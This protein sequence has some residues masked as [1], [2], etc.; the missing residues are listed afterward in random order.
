MLHSLRA[1]PTVGQSWRAPF[2]CCW[3]LISRWRAGLVRCVSALCPSPQLL[4]CFRAGQVT[5]CLCGSKTAFC[6]S[7]LAGIFLKPAKPRLSHFLLDLYPSRI[8]FCPLCSRRSNRQT[9]PPLLLP[10]GDCVC[11]Y[12]M[13]ARTL[14]APIHLTGD[15]AGPVRGVGERS[16]PVARLPESRSFLVAS[17]AHFL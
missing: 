13:T 7:A 10:A 3:V 8:L 16:N 4:A 17:P 2:S 5:C 11:S 12:R 14:H 15:G 9:F 6:L 1:P